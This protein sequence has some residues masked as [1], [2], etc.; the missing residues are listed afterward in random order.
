MEVNLLPFLKD[1]QKQVAGLIIKNRKPDEKPQDQQQEPDDSAAAIESCA[2]ALINAIHS[3]DVQAAAQAL[4][5]AFDILESE[6][7]EQEE[8]ASPHSYDAQNQLAAKQ[9]EE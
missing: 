9:S 8:S 6:E 1:K 3:K 4:K 2:D 7:D 5:D